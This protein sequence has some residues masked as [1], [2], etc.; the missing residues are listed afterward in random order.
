MN[1]KTRATASRDLARI[2]AGLIFATLTSSG[3]TPVQRPSFEAF[4]VATIKPTAPNP[5]GLQGRW[6]RMQ[7]ADRFEAHNHA[8]RTL[9]AAAYD[10]SPQ[11]I[12]DGPLGLIPSV[13]IF[14]RKHRGRFG[15]I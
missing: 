4:E 8:I 9:I 1:T 6:I 10:L 12:S 3:Q 13:G 7:S 14:L 5:Q 15:L 2:V 11:A